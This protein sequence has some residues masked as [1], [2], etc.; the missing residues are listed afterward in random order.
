MTDTC[1]D[2]S[3]ASGADLLPAVGDLLAQQQGFLNDQ[4]HRHLDSGLRPLFDAEDVL[5]EARLRIARGMEHARFDSL[6]S[7]RAWLATIVRN[8][9]FDLR[10]RHLL[11]QKRATATE[12]LDQGSVTSLSGVTTHRR[13]R[14]P[15]MQPGPS[16][17]V[18]RAEE[19]R[20]LERAMEQL[21]PH[22][23]EILQL[24]YFQ[25][26]RVHDIAARTGRK[27]DAVRKE[28]ARAV[29]ACRGIIAALERPEAV[30]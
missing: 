12:S 6:P 9:V 26:L 27:P 25:H 24:V 14:L 29:I 23:R 16:S 3:L 2:P 30:E 1:L 5:Q 10:R 4:V 7:F 17:I 11:A 15:A 8:V 19:V 21:K 22:H 13:D 18:R 20:Q 28:L